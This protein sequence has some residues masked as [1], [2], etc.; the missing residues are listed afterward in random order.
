M[1]KN[2]IIAVDTNFLIYSVKYRID[3]FSGLLM[4]F[5]SYVL[6]YPLGVE[7]ELKGLSRN[8][9]KD[10]MLAKI[11]LSLLCSMKGM[12]HSE[13]VDEFLMNAD[14][15]GIGAV[16]THDKKII[17]SIKNKKIAVVIIRG[18]KHLDIA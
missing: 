5:G 14:A 4:L 6:I 13:S 3:L 18:K 1:R 9:S 7:R 8:K 10:G 12:K 11:A 15:H 17:E 16:C 2:F